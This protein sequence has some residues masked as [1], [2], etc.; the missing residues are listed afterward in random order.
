MTRRTTRAIAL[1]A[2]AALAACTTPTRP[3]S[4]PTV[5]D[6]A[7]PVPRVAAQALALHAGL[8]RGLTLQ[9]AETLHI[10]TLDV[11]DPLGHPFTTLVFTSTA[12]IPDPWT[13]APAAPTPRDAT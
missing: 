11:E 12:P 6:L 5:L 8:E 2:T 1:A 10:A 9:T 4:E 3:P 13:H 7:R